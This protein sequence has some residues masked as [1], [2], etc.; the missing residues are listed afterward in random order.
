[1]TDYTDNDRIPPQE[2][3]RLTKIMVSLWDEHFVDGSRMG[4]KVGHILF[5]KNLSCKINKSYN[6]L[7]L[8]MNGLEGKGFT[9]PNPIRILEENDPLA[10]SLCL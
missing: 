2:S 10:A 8:N 9:I 5:L 7:E 4:I 1:M 3:N 6:K